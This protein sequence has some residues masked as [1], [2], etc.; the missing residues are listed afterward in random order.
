[1]KAELYCFDDC[2]SYVQAFTNLKEALRLEQMPDDVE[3]AK[4]AHAADAQMKRFLWS[5]T[6]RLDG[7]DIEGADAETHGY[8]YGFRVYAD[9]GHTVGG[10]PPQPTSQT[11]RT[12]TIGVKRVSTVQ[13]IALLTCSPTL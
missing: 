8:A 4:V 12:S 13:G 7:V 1:M 10:S 3:M 2:P 6:I 5:P 11:A 9:D